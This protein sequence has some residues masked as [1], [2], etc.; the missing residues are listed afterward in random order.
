MSAATD[1]YRQHSPE[2]SAHAF[3]E[4]EGKSCA[5]CGRRFNPA[6]RWPRYSALY[7]GYVC[8]HDCEPDR[9]PIIDLTPG[10]ACTDC[11]LIHAGECW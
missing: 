11:N 6:H 7:E 3:A 5:A 2:A 8:S 10:K 4:Y 1:T 9:D